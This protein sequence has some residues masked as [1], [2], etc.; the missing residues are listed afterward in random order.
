MEIQNR[1]KNFTMDEAN[2]TA[3]AYSLETAMW[4][5]I[6]LI[7]KRVV[8][9][10]NEFAVARLPTVPYYIGVKVQV[11]HDFSYTFER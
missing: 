2:K 3:L 9:P 5:L 6:R 1:V 10:Q 8:E 11:K 7:E 4:R